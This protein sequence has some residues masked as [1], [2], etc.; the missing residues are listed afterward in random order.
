M[1]VCQVACLPWPQTSR[2]LAD[3]DIRALDHAARQ[4]LI[5]EKLNEILRDLAAQRTPDVPCLLL[6]HCGIDTA[7]MG[8]QNR[9]GMLGGEWTLNTHEL[10]AMGFDAVVL[11]HYHRP[12][13]LNTAPWIGYTGSPECIDG[14]EEG[15]EKVYMTFDLTEA[16]LGLVFGHQ[17]PYR[18]FLSIRSDQDWRPAVDEAG[19]LD[20]AIVR[21]TVP[22]VE[23]NRTD[24]LRQ[25]LLSCGAAEVQVTIE[26]AEATARREHSVTASTG[27]PEAL[28]EY[29][30]QHPGLEPMLPE[31]VEEAAAL[32]AGRGG[33]A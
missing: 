1:V 8:K 23:A 27:V 25:T 5:R 19:G 24:E 3:A 15:E 7:E 29:A 9:L 18:R 31:L 30:K 12:Q 10:A 4:Q 6:A 33:E 2:L 11:G 21:L 16:G 14:G 32:E 17:T 22:S 13:V 26:R 20:G 28:A